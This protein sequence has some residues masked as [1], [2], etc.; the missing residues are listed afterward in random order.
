MAT[1][2]SGDMTAAAIIFG[3]WGYQPEPPMENLEQWK[4][5]E[6]RSVKAP[7]TGPP[8]PT[9]EAS[10]EAFHSRLPLLKLY[11]NEKHASFVAG[12]IKGNLQN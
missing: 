8:R 9:N 10:P 1:A 7:I 5:L 12:Q 6:E 2:V 4:A 11:L 3:G